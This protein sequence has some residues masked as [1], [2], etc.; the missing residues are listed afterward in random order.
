MTTPRIV[1]LGHAAD[2]TGPPMYLLQ[3][4]TEWDLDDLD[5]TLVLLRGGDLLADFEALVPVRV[6]GEPVDRARAEPVRLAEEPA[7]V[8]TRRAQLA[9]L[10]DIDLVVV[11]TAWSI[12]ALAWLPEDPRRTLAVVHELSAGIDLLDQSSLA[13]LLGSDRFLAGCSAVADLL[14]DRHGVDRDRIDLVP[15]GVAL[16]P[17][18]HE[19]G[20]GLDLEEASLQV[21]ADACTVVAAAVPDRRKGPDLFVHLAAAARRSRPDVAWA[22]RWI[23]ATDDDPRLADAVEDRALLGADDLVRFLPATPRLRALLAAADIFVL[24]SREDA[25]PLA[26]LEASLAGLPILCF[27]TG[28]IGVLVGGDAG[29]VVAFPEVEAMADVLADWHDRPDHRRRLGATG[30][31]RVRAE[32]DVRRHASAVRRLVDELLAP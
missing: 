25:F 18:E 30:R 31:D 14:A 32:H 1:V 13:T 15:Y 2:R 26:V 12:H 11:N 10:V 29:A 9:D 8:V 22:F 20:G 5:V 24:P 4:L 16:D 6:V 7:R 23:G 19:P 3:L 17:P 28:G 21:D 27:D